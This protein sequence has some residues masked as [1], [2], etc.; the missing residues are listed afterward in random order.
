M[1]LDSLAMG[2][3]FICSFAPHPFWARLPFQVLQAMLIWWLGA[4]LA[5]VYVG[6]LK[7]D[8]G[9]LAPLVLLLP[10]LAAVSAARK[11]H[12]LKW[13]LPSDVS[14]ILWALGFCGLMAACFWWQ[15]RGRNLGLLTRLK[16]VGEMSYTLYVTHFPIILF[17]AGWLLHVKHEA[18]PP[19]TE[20]YVLP[21]VAIAF[22]F[23]WLAH[24][25]VE[26][27]F[28]AGPRRVALAHKEP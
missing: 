28:L 1:G 23:A 20:I 19:R 16:W 2:V 7:V 4:L 22:S 21:A 6:R 10:L 24:F 5:E 3:L 13:Y 15:G 8:M 11:L 26:R 17:L 12:L 18:A 14:A 9:R 27:P 25:V